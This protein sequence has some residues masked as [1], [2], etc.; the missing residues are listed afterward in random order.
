MKLAGHALKLLVLVAL[1]ISG[2]A[3]GFRMS[4]GGA[5]STAMDWEVMRRSYATD[6]PEKVRSVAF[7]YLRLTDRADD[8]QQLARSIAISRVV[9]IGMTANL[10]RLSGASDSGTTWE[11]FRRACE[12][13]R[14]VDCTPEGLSRLA[15]TF[16]RGRIP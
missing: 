12:N 11:Q 13:A 14:W 4:R 7:E 5:L 8:H 10:A 15:R 9:T 3:T 6:P 2:F 16:P 1:A